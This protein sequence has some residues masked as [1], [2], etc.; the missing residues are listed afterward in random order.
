MP[1]PGLALRLE[2]QAVHA[3]AVALPGRTHEAFVEGD[4]G[5]QPGNF[6]VAVGQGQRDAAWLASLLDRVDRAGDVTVLPPHGL[7]LE[8]VGYPDDDQLAARQLEAR[9]RRDERP[10]P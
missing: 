4:V 7:V 5:A 2:L 8:E 6:L 9:A 3:Q 10:L 1:D